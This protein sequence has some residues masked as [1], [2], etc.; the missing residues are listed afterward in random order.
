MELAIAIPAYNEVTTLR[1][2]VRASLAQLDLLDADGIVFVVDD[3]ST[4]GTGALA[5]ALAAEDRRV[6]VHHH[7]ENRGFSGAIRTALTASGADF[8]FLIPADGQVPVDILPRFWDSRADADVI[9]G[10]RRPRADTRWRQFLSWGYHAIS[11]LLLGIRLTEFSSTLLARRHV[12]EIPTASRPRSAALLAE[13]MARGQRSGA[14]FK[15]IPYRHLPRAGGVPKGGDLR[16]A[17]H[18]FF[19]LLRIASLL[20]VRERTRAAPAD[21]ALEARS[22]ESATITQPGD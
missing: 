6:V 4:D 16:I 21:T 11:R 14:R 20:R 19:E 10:V 18:T 8:V 7:P 3:G 9:L 17:A 12:L 22:S 1:D 13:V 2:V 15:E 5:D